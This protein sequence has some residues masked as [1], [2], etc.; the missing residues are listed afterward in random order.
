MQRICL[1]V[2]LVLLLA[3]GCSKGGQSGE[4]TSG[5]SKGTSE[6]PSFARRPDALPPRSTGAPVA[7]ENAYKAYYFECDDYWVVAQFEIRDVLVR[8]PDGRFRLTPEETREGT[9]FSNGNA[10]L[11]PHGEEATFEIDGRRYENCRNNPKKAVWEGARARGVNYRAVGNEPGW[12]LEIESRKMVFVTN[13]GE[14]KFVFPTPMPEIEPE[15]SA[16]Y[17]ASN[18]GH[19]IQVIIRQEKCSDTMDGEE[20]DNRVEATLDGVEYNGCGRL[21]DLPVQ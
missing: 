15:V 6:Q 17:S 2:V 5:D 10:A 16:T 4:Q 19:Q 14:D 9:R 12:V 18:D 21:L 11:W 7:G 3:C 13:Y 1:P 20:F 8:T